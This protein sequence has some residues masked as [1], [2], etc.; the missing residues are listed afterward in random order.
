[1]NTYLIVPDGLKFQVIETSPDGSEYFVRGFYSKTDALVW[2]DDYDRM[3]ARWHTHA[4]RN[5][6][7]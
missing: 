1:V 2:I 5:A 6:R 7:P 4:A 3:L